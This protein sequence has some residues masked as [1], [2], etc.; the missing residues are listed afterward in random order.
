MSCLFVDTEDL[1]VVL[2]GP[3]VRQKASGPC[4]FGQGPRNSHPATRNSPL[5]KLRQ[6][7]PATLTSQKLQF[8]KMPCYCDYA[9]LF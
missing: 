3:E 8:V 7:K 2:C 6:A 9:D 1:G 4:V 5:F